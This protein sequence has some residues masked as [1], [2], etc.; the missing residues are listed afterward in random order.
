MVIEDHLVPSVSAPLEFEDRTSD[1]Y[2]LTAIQYQGEEI[3]WL[4]R[5]NTGRTWKSSTH[6]LKTI[7]RWSAKAIPSIQQIAC[8]SDLL[9]LNQVLKEIGHEDA[10]Y[11]PANPEFPFD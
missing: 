7:W 3:Q 11:P 9:L 10:W 4:S 6:F 2:R 5:E 1:N 8:L